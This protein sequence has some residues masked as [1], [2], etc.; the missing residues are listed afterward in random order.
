MFTARKH[1]VDQITGLSIG[2][3]D[4]V[5]KPVEPQVLV[6]RI[7]ALLRRFQPRDS[8]ENSKALE[9]GPVKTQT[10]NHEL[11]ALVMTKLSSPAMNSI[12]CGISPN[13]RAI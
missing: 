10:P 13:M 7:E 2:A 4:Y 6:A 11:R 1:D 12:C 3:D 5:V 9:F 8:L